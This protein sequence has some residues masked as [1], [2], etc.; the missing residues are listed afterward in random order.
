MKKHKDKPQKDLPSIG[1]GPIK[2]CWEGGTAH[3]FNVMPGEIY[4]KDNNVQR[5]SFAL[6]YR[7]LLCACGETKEIIAEDRGWFTLAK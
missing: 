5:P 6:G 4:Y 2:Q 3:T 7:M 1:T